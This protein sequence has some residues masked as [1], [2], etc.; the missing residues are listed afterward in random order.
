MSVDN[1]SSKQLANETL[2]KLIE[3][4]FFNP[5]TTLVP[6]PSENGKKCAKYISSLYCE[7]TEMYRETK[8]AQ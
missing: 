3:A 6:D 2:H 8:K 1:S 4:G 5:V 7:L